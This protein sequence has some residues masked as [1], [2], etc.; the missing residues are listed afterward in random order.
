MVSFLFIPNMLSSISSLAHP[1]VSQIFWT[2]TCS[3]S[4]F[5]MYY[6]CASFSFRRFGQV[7][8]KMFVGRIR[9]ASSKILY[10]KTCRSYRYLVFWYLVWLFGK[11]DCAK[12]QIVFSNRNWLK[13]LFKEL[14]QITTIKYTN[15]HWE[16]SFGTSK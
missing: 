6:L 5:E 9:Y 8:L 12:F 14:R 7:M 4:A 3:K 10:C 15:C 1:F 2:R 16:L 13:K 11:S